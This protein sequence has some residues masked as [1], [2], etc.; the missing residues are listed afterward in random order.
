MQF[1]I[2]GP[3]R[4]TTGDES[5]IAVGWAKPASL[6]AML[7]LRPNEAL[8]AGQLIEDLWDGVPP[9][10][11]AKTLQVHVSRLRRSLE[12]AQNGDRGAA[13]ETTAAGY[14]LRVDR[15]SIDAVRFEEL[16]AEGTA[17]LADGAHA[18]AS[19]RVREGLKLWRGEALADFAYASFAQD[20]IARLDGLRTVAAETAIEAELAL[21]RHAQLVPELKF[22]V[23][24]YPLSE[25]LRAQLMLALYRAGRQAEA[26]GVYRAGR[27]VLVDQLGIEPGEE[28]RELERA[29][30]AQDGTLATPAAQAPVRR[31]RSER[32]SRG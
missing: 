8:A 19:A 29:I 22:L 6:L 5:E 17:A 14:L 30:L 24:R 20:E 2:L 21:G 15:A 13:I 4:V 1:Q 18:R 3:L 26:L 25:H 28:L 23:K 32:S 16:V 9:Q 12:Q 7:L 10:T 31:A 11:A 27:R